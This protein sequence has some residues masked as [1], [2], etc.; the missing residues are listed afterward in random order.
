M[1]DRFVDPK[2]N[3]DSATVPRDLEEFSGTT[4]AVM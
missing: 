2:V 4:M 3:F 1:G